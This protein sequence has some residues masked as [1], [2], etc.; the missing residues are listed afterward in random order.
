MSDG[1]DGLQLLMRDHRQIER[2]YDAFHR[3]RA[4]DAQA[5]YR[6]A[7]L[8][9]FRMAA[10]SLLE[11]QLFYPMLREAGVDAE[12]IDEAI[13]EQV[14][15]EE[16][17]S[18]IVR[19]GPHASDAEHRVHM[20]GQLAREHVWSQEREVFPYAQIVRVDAEKLAE[21]LE[22]LSE[23]A[24]THVLRQLAAVRAARPA[25]EARRAGEA[26]ADA[27]RRGPG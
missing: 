9:C 12:F 20:L 5:R 3:T 13:I 18:G 21:Q 15:L 24:N 17:V 25:E 22:Q 23:R 11:T 16:I 2:L 6:V 14:L 27:R 26:A 1:R 4:A 7:H 19:G 8:L 10:H